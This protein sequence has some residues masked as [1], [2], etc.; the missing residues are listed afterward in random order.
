MTLA[1]EES[2]VTQQTMDSLNQI[3]YCVE[4]HPDATIQYIIHDPLHTYQFI[5]DVR[6]QVLHPHRRL[7]L[8]WKQRLQSHTHAKQSN[9]HPS[10]YFQN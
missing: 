8:S 7:F 10:Q 9:P 2:K 3:L 1:A 4:I 5:V 6:T